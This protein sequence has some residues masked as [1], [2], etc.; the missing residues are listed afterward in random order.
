MAADRK[1]ELLSKVRMFSSLNRK[2]LRLIARTSDVIQVPKGTEIVT[3]GKL[4]HEFYLILS[5]S[6]SVRRGGRKV[7]SLSTGDYF[8]EMA[9]LDKGPRTASIVAEEDCELLLLGQR[10][11][12]SVLDQVPPVAH[13]LLVN[14]ASRLREADSRAVSH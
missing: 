4:G 11:F 10:E 5:G 6:A 2:E 9:L 1:L 13:K 7:A 14:M 12:M 3:E 8:G